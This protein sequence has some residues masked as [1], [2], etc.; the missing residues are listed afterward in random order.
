M[1]KPYPRFEHV[2][3][4]APRDGLDVEEKAIL[5]THGWLGLARCKACGDTPDYVDKTTRL[6]RPCWRVVVLGS[7]S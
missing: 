4:Y 7:A 2:E 3:A 6:C 1:S 5:R